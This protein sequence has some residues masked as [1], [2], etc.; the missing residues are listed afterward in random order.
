MQN[1]GLQRSPRIHFF[2]VESRSR[3]P[4]EPRR[5]PIEFMRLTF[6]MAM[7]GFTVF[8]GCES[9]TPSDLDESRFWGIIDDAWESHSELSDY[10]SSLLRSTRDS[11]AGHEVGLIPDETKLIE[12]I[13]SQLETLSKSELLAFDR[14]LERKLYEID[15]ADIHDR[16]G[17]SDD[18]FLYCRAFIVAVGRDYYEAV[19][20]DPA[21]AI[22]GD[23]GLAYTSAMIYERKFGPLP[24]SG[25]SRESQSNA[26]GWKRNDG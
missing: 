11:N 14:I 12:K 10:R 24:P 26:A 8:P 21:L 13:E 20:A 23:C 4:A 3:G 25:I 7:V 17:G 6:V 9:R 15:R 16:T 5:Y 2:E 19:Y 1:H 22:E 18:G